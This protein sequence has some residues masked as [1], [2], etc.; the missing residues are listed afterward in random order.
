M[1]ADNTGHLTAAAR[2][3][4]EQTR[5]RATAALRRMDATGAPVSIQTVAR[6]AGV[7]RSWLYAQPDLRGEIE[8]LRARRR[9]RQPTPHPPERQRASD[10]SLLRRLEAATERIR[11]LEQDNQHLRDALS[12]A[13]GERRTADILGRTGSGDTPEQ[14]RPNVIGPC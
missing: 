8:R 4:A 10:A 3:R 12:R 9:P 1:R 13:L 11:R 7:S 2:R 14:P 6:Q 5:Q